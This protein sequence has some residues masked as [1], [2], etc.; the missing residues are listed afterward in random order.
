MWTVARAAVGF[1]RGAFVELCQL[2]LVFV[3]ALLGVSLLARPQATSWIALVPGLAVFAGY[4]AFALL[5][6]RDLVQGWLGMIA[7]RQPGRYADRAENLGRALIQ[8]ASVA[9]LV[10]PAL[11]RHEPYETRGFASAFL[12]LAILVFGVGAA[13]P[14]LWFAFR[15]AP[16][17]APD[18]VP[19]LLREAGRRAAWL[20][21]CSFMGIGLGLAAA[22]AAV[23]EHAPPPVEAPAI[24][25]A[26][27]RLCRPASDGCPDHRELGMVAI[28]TGRMAASLVSDD[29]LDSP[30][31]HVAVSGAWPADPAARAALEA[32]LDADDGGKTTIP[33]HAGEYV[34]LAVSVPDGA[35]TCTFFLDLD[36]YDPG[37]P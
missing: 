8:L 22:R 11:D 4:S 13:V 26:A 31:C 3:A 37:A 10:L 20:F 24:A 5:P 29:A 7:G 1:A 16:D 18:H 36:Q 33:V 19:D 14:R 2:V 30:V 34:A 27:G 32:A 9:L 21:Y 17:D 35:D 28:R 23:F 6:A 15:T 25:Q 12:L